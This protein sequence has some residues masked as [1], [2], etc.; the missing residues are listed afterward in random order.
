MNI[1]T[2]IAPFYD[3]FMTTLHRRQ[4]GLLLARLAPWHGCRVLDLGGGTGRLAVRFKKAGADVWL[5]D[6]SE[7][8]LKRASRL[9]PAN[10]II[11]GDAASLPFAK[12][13]FDLI[14]LVDAFHHLRNQ[15]AALQE[16]FRVLIPGGTLAILDFTPESRFVRALARLE[17][18]VQEPALFLTVAELARVLENHGF[19][20]LRT[21]RISAHEYLTTGTKPQATG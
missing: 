13:D 16:A 15:Q 4:G 7:S 20:E 9:L 11:L 1:F 5:L 12:N 2:L 14:T 21:L 8:M 6:A 10:R 3:A 19:I 17:R 18:L